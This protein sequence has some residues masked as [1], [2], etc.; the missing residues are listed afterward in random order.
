MLSNQDLQGLFAVSFQVLTAV[1]EHR[2]YEHKLLFSLSQR[3]INP[4]HNGRFRIPRYKDDGIVA[5]PNAFAD[6]GRFLTS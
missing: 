6:T 5:T 3:P 4:W 1:A 2:T